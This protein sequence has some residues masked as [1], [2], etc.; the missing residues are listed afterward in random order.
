[1]NTPSRHHAQIPALEAVDL[2][3]QALP[4]QGLFAG[5]SWRLSP[6]AFPL[7]PAT[8]N[9]LEQ[10]GPLLHRFQRASDTLYR[11]SHNGSLPAWLH[12]YLDRGKPQDLIDFGIDPRIQ[13]QLPRV[14]RPDL[15]LT[16][17]G[18]TMVELDSVPG[19]IGLTA[20]LN[21][22]YSQSLRDQHIIGGAD[23]MLKGFASI[24]KNA[25]HLV[26]SKESADYRPECDW[27]VQQLNHSL[28]TDQWSVHG[29][30]GYT[31]QDQQ[32][33][34]RFFELF[35]LPNL[36]GI[37]QLAKQA[38]AD[39]HDLSAPFKA[40]L[41][42]KMWLSLFWSK[43]LQGVWQRELRKANW[44]RLQKIIPQAWIL[45]PSDIPH[46]AVIPGLEIN[47]FDELKHFTQKEREYVLK[48]SGFSEIGWGSR[49][50]SIGHDLSQKEWSA[51]IDTALDSFEH[52]P[53]VL[54]KFHS[55]KL[56]QHPYLD[57][58]SGSIVTMEG[59]VR[60]CPYY[61]T[62]PASSA[63]GLSKVKLG[64]VLATLCPADKK[65]LHGMSEAV[66]MPCRVDPDGY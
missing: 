46:H 15:I 4:K 66:I 49:S 59:R 42:E 52:H 11:R 65:I 12:Q 25:A 6:Q 8:L 21:Q 5:K 22:T 43:P 45:D 63:T 51:A 54:Q 30:E 9:Q 41:E 64:G 44:K 7:S 24:F 47:H 17:Q 57:T 1:M 56:V 35:D 55:G 36:P 23:G 33:V 13:S 58:E 14:I 34:Y 38:A 3:R 26:I 50:V 39:E 53:Y 61:F 60:L 32:A 37:N 31:N 2:I 19:G 40:F 48:I 10:I 62:E 18:L 16:E 20:W 27:L 28:N 29:A